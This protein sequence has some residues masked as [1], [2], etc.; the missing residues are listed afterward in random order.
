MK[1]GFVKVAVCSPEIKVADTVYNADA[2][3][4]TIDDVIRKDAELIV[5]PELC[6]TGATCG[7]LFLTK[8]LLS[9]A[10]SAVLKIAQATVG[11]KA[12]IFLGAPVK[13]GN[14]I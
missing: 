4:K 2:V 9:G 12:L 6:L 3:I 5:F 11:K 10:E 7:D 8:T 14:L 13:N 1:F